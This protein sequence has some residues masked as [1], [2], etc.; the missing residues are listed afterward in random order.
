M[1][2]LSSP[3]APRDSNP[4]MSVTVGSKALQRDGLVAFVEDAGRFETRGAW[5]RM[6]PLAI[7]IHLAVLL[8]SMCLRPSASHA[9]A[10]PVELEYIEAPAVENTP[11]PASDMESEARPDIPRQ[12]AAPQP[13]PAPDERAQAGKVLTAPDQAQGRGESDEIV[14]GESDRFAGGTTAASGTATQAV[15]PP[16][17]PPVPSAA[18][19][20]PPT[21]DTVAAT[22][23]YL[24]RVRQALAREKRYPMSAQRLGIEGTVV[25]S[26][27]IGPTGAFSGVSVVASSGNDLLDQAALATVSALSGRIPRPVDTGAVTLP[28]RTSLQFQMPK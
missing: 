2:D 27:S 10:A 4:P 12:Q 28:L 19:P 5:I 6:F 26:L 21:V 11:P 25:V 22:R 15:A 23:A 18:P 24:G 16:P 8:G 14:S 7:A 1:R 13:P 20:P 17:P 3:P 9:A